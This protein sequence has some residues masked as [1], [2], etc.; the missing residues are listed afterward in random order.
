MGGFPSRTL[1]DLLLRKLS[2]VFGACEKECQASAHMLW[3]HRNKSQVW[4]TMPIRNPGL[5][6]SL[7]PRNANSVGQVEHAG[8]RCAP[9]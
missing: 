3:P 4:N 7:E 6:R 8:C 9:A 2:P 1:S 5:R